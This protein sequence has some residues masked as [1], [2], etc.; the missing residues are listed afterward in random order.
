M[1]GAD[2]DTFLARLRAAAEPTRLRLLALCASAELTVSEVT[3]I[4]NQSQPR[5]SRHL[6]LLCDAGLINRSR[7][8]TWAFYRL[9]QGEAGSLARS[10][11]SQIPVDDQVLTRDQARLDAVNKQ[12]ADAAAEYFRQNAGR[13]SEIRKLHV[14]EE[15][16]EKAILKSFSNQ[17]IENYL[18]IG[19]G[20]GRLLE[21][22]GPQ[23]QSATGVDLSHEMLNMARAALESSGL[24]NCQ[25]R[26]G[27]MYDLPFEAASQDAVTLH[28]VLHYADDP[29]SVIDE[30]ARVLRKDG[31]LVVIDF[32]PHNEESL[33]QEH[34]HRRLGFSDIDVTTWFRQSG[35]K[36][37]A[38]EV[39]EG[40]PLSVVLWS[41]TKI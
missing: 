9:A 37:A 39:L 1:T 17:T 21:L 38:P 36:S 33:R 6:K 8:G 27:D 30:A 10:L 7:E 19:T 20:T 24:E 31:R 3:Q 4:L 28:Q 32:A 35:L 25:V 22:L 29:A 12:R 23:V 15:D 11:I 5:V 34:A 16:V 40:D 41:G 13:W 26:L 14:P 18:D 2:M